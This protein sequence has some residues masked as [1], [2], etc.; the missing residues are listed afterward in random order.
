MSTDVRRCWVCHQTLP[1]HAFSHN[2]TGTDTIHQKR[3][4][5]RTCNTR[6]RD[7]W[8]ARMSPER[9]EAYRQRHLAYLRSYSDPRRK[10]AARQRQETIK[11]LLVMLNRL[12]TAGY[13][14]WRIARLAG[15]N[16]DT[17]YRWEKNTQRRCIK[18]ETVN[19]VATVYLDWVG[20]R[21]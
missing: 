19:K 13:S 10:D 9:Y 11:T 21:L 20:G 8:V 3:Y 1:I 16:P 6:Q 5:C 4:C 18:R 15:M 7:R 17:L 2:T 12:N 14:T